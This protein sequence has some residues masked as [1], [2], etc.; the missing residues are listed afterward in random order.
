MAQG[1]QARIV[2]QVQPNA[3]RNQV[4][5]YQEGVLHLK[6][7]A[8]PVKG[9]ANRELVKFLAETLGVSRG[10]LS[11]ESGLTNKR[12]VITIEGLTQDQVIIQLE[13][14]PAE[15]TNSPRGA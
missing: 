4:V 9:K 8:A 10:S 5:R 11:I 3:S 1:E 15:R 6:I 12:K 2:V 13:K 14:G 7:A